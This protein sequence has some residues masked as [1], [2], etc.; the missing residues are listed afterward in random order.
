MAKK[1]KALEVK[2]SIPDFWKN[3]QRAKAIMRQLSELQ[4]QQVFWTKI[5][6]D[7]TDLTELAKI[8]HDPHEQEALHK[9]II[10]LS[11]EVNA[12]ELILFMSGPYDAGDAL[13]SIHA[14]TG[15]T[16]ANDFAEMLLRMYLRYAEQQG[17]NVLVLEKNTATEAGI[18]NTTLLIKGRF[19]YGY[20]RGE[21][22]VHRLV[23]QSPFNA[24]ALRQT[25]FAL[26]EVLPDIQDA[27]VVEIKPDEIEID[28]FR[29]SGA[30]GQHVNKT[31]SA[32]RITHKPTGVVA[33]CQ[34]ERSQAQNKEQ[35]I[36]LLT[37]KLFQRVQENIDQERQEVKGEYKE[38]KWGNQIRSYVLHPYT[39]VKDHRT[40]V[41][42]PH[43]QGVLDGDLQSFLE[44]Y[45]RSTFGH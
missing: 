44:G 6:A 17:Y 3:E 35:A 29:A 31:D 14:G 10:T 27:K 13:L 25:S 22:G 21:A 26:V 32:V 45:L 30:G 36:K 28:T 16:D 41:E 7:A 38:A 5:L 42:T 23:R 37:A 18:K 11:Q 4:E 43:A 34:S 39:M 8:T 19:A 12:K 2:A 40:K 33:A 24:D 9:Q 1:I 15:G 20:L